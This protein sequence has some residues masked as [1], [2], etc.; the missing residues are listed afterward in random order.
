[1]DHPQGHA[2][3]RAD[4]SGEATTQD[5]D[6]V[7]RSLQSSAHDNVNAGEQQF[8]LCGGQ[9]SDALSE[10]CFVERND[11]RHVRHRILGQISRSC[12]EPYIARRVRPFQ[13]TRQWHADHGSDSTAVQS[14]ALD[15]DDGPPKSGF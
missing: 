11:L 3:S 1:M 15:Y 10:N 2:E 7:A 9:L 12:T 14:V 5:I 6:E 8:H 4:A 13:I